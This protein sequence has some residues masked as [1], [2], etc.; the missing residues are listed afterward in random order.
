MF[1]APVTTRQ[2]R[3]P[4]ATGLR[5][6]GGQREEVPPDLAPPDPDSG[7][8][9][10]RAVQYHTVLQQCLEPRPS[11]RVSAGWNKQRCDLPPGFAAPEVTSLFR[12][13]NSPAAR[14]IT[15]SRR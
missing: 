11:N 14:V 5:Y 3:C 9:R 13:G 10:K 6:R 12:A 15:A 1:C 4:V 2:C 7:H 8:R